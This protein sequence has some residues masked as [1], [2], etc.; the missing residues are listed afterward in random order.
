MFIVAGPAGVGKSALIHYL[1]AAHPAKLS[2]V[3]AYTTRAIRDGEVNGVDYHFLSV[4]QFE[5]D[6]K[7]DK[8]IQ[9]VKLNDN[10]YGTTKQSV[11][12]ILK[13]GKKCVIDVNMAGLQA[14]QKQL[15]GG[16]GVFL[17]VKSPSVEEL[18]RRLT[19][20]RAGQNEIDNSLK[21]YEADLKLLDTTE[22]K[23]LV[24]AV[25]VNQELQGTY[26]D[27]CDI[28]KLDYAVV[29]TAVKMEKIQRILV[30]IKPSKLESRLAVNHALLFR[31]ILNSKI[32]LLAI[33][34]EES[35]KLKEYVKGLKDD[36]GE[37]SFEYVHRKNSGDIA[38][39]II[40]EAE[41]C[42]FV[43]MGTA[44]KEDFENAVLGSTSEEV[45]KL[46][47]VPVITIRGRHLEAV[48]P[49]NTYKKWLVVHDGSSN[50][51]NGFVKAMLPLAKKMNAELTIMH[52]VPFDA[53][54]DTPQREKDQAL[55]H[56]QRVLDQAK[57][58]C[59]VAGVTATTS[60]VTMTESIPHTIMH[61]M[62]V[63]HFS[64]IAMSTTGKKGL[65]KVFKESITEE[66]VRRSWNPVLTFN[67]FNSD[68][69]HGDS[70]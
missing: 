4:E 54:D 28:F 46:C 11:E 43:V 57:N 37:D 31:K 38:N 39:I 33:S 13:G 7:A 69:V 42:E 67:R 23:A 68:S 24:D 41:R 66:I 58:Y 59:S 10:Y 40:K 52:V 47:S 63:G 25:I 3:V 5:A 14:Y 34:D 70:K 26:K 49:A 9:H 19:E 65:E 45:L 35:D 61:A 30:P 22:G 15:G 60:L 36:F 20:R 53:L 18:Q 21:E 8:F 64:L 51:K 32:V 27:I 6:I 55:G 56:A 12:A 2:K 44:G 16:V 50:S 17:Y 48:D 29:P 1:L 62:K